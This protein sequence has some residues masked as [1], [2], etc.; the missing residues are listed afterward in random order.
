MVLRQEDFT[1]QAQAALGSSQDLVMQMR[2]SQWDA[3]HLLLG[4]LDVSDGLPARLLEKLGVS[5][6]EIAAEIRS[7]LGSAPKLS[8]QQSTTSQIFATPRVRAV[9]DG[10]REES[11]RLKDEFISTEHLLLALAQDGIGGSVARAFEKRNITKE[12]I[13]QALLDVR[14]S[15]R[16]TDQRAESKYQALAKY[17][18]DL[19]GLARKGRL[20]P[21]V[22]RDAEIRRVM[23]TLSRRTKNNPVLI[24]DAGVGKTAIVEGLAQRIYNGDVPESLKGRTVIAL[25]MGSLI[26]GA[27]FRGE[28]EERLKA[29][30]DEIKDAAGE[31]VLFIDEIHT[32]VGAGAG[33]DGALDASNMMKPALAR[34]EMQ[35]IGATTPDEYRKRI[36]ADK[37][38]ERRFSPI[39]VE[40]P[41]IDDTVQ[42]LR[43][44][45]PRYEKHH[46]IKIDD[47]ALESAALL[48][49]RY[50]SD[51]MLPDKA[52]DLIDEA[53][54]RLR[55]ENES[56]PAELKEEE[57]RI[58]RLVEEESSAS[59]RGDYE[60][61]AGHRSERLRSS[62]KFDQAK[63]AWMANHKVGDTVDHEL[64]AELISERT[65]I[66]V[67]RFVEGEAERLLH[68]EDRLHRRVIGQESAVTALSDAIRRAR[69]G[70]K[71]PKRPIGSFIFLGPTGVGK[72]EL[73]RALA[74]Y[75]FDDEENMVRV[76]M[77]EYQERHAVS[78]L[79]GA[80]PG[81]VGFDD[82]GQLT[83][84]IRR[85]PFSVILFDEIEKAHP[86][87]FNT[88][89]QV[90]DDGRLTDGQGRTVDFR[91]TVIIMTSNLGTQ[92]VSEEAL[93]FQGA[94]NDSDKNQRFRSSIDTSLKRAFRPEFL[95][96][97]DDI[98]VFDP[99]T[100]D[101][102]LLIV[103]KMTALVR[104]RVRELDVDIE[105]TM[106]GR[107]WLAEEGFDKMYGARP[108]ARA[109]QRHL[110]N[111]LSKRIL[112]GDF[113]P[114]SKIV[115][116]VE[117]D[118]LTFAE[119]GIPMLSV[120]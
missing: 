34:G 36:E 1:E 35:T 49:A 104:E 30:M 39:W 42:M 19:T 75:L 59:E 91:N 99:L 9:I 118:R 88:L 72:T 22:G 95:N 119:S 83:E 113:G 69:A 68:L 55:I 80:P 21:V 48:G 57:A 64:I 71:D 62:Q 7:G 47:Q 10:A 74:E 45:R 81:Y 23:Q 41:S 46:G 65:G 43:N 58:Q 33:G 52:V 13:Y 17:S 15:Q 67:A 11:K 73:A 85:R 18:V 76:D 93:G 116:D 25:D 86:D 60:A 50:I 97:I 26:A 5:P 94:R 111:P 40:E 112:S 84:S 38:L 2:H 63:A 24:G 44:L 120:T 109:I 90:L 70:L 102:I 8:H 79:I 54:A 115:V 77:S 14:G 108:L 12:R 89:L 66:P 32:V 110:E 29:V 82:G 3:E 105:L 92:G 106:A 61:A 107:R 27:K 31:I 78:R 117:N 4:L 20:D 28:F 101:D 87:V 37:A 98:I 56:F 51:R 16:V 103:D 114:G 96:R 100:R 53:A 6:A